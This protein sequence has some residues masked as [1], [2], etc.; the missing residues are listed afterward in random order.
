MGWFDEQIKQRMTKDQQVFEESYENFASIFEKH[1]R[2]EFKEPVGQGKNAIEQILRYFHIQEVEDTSRFQTI[3]ELLEHQLRPYGI[4]KR[5][6][7]LDK[8]W[9]RSCAGV[10][11]AKTKNDDIVA[12]IPQGI[13]G[14]K[15][16]DHHLNKFVSINKRNADTILPEA[17][18][19]YKSFPLRKIN[20]KDIIKYIFQIPTK[21]EYI[22]ML[23][24]TII[25]TLVGM[26]I[27]PIYHLF[28]SNI[29]ESNQMMLLLML[30]MVY[31]CVKLSHV[32]FT[33]IHSIY[34]LYIQTKIQL[35]IESAAMLRLLT[36]PSK[37]FKTY[38]I[39]EIYNRL[40]QMKSLSKIIAQAI[41]SIGFISVFSLIYISQIFKYA[42]TLVILALSVTLILFVY[43]V[44]NTWYFAHINEQR[45]ILE[46]KEQALSYGLINGIS[47]IKLA[48]AEKRVFSKWS[49]AYMK[50]ARK[51]YNLPWI[52]KYQQPITIFISGIGMMLLYYYALEVQLSVANYMAFI[53]A[54]GMVSGAFL[55]LSDMVSSFADIKPILQMVKPILETVP[56][57][58]TDKKVITR[59][60]GAI[61]VSHVNF[62]YAADTP[63]VLDDVT[64]KI[65]AGE[66][67]AIVGSTGSGK[68]T[69]LRLLLGFEKANRGT[70]YYDHQDIERIDLKSLRQHIGV[71]LQD[72]KLFQGDIFS[73][74]TIS[75]PNATL[76]EAWKACEEVGIANDIE[77]MP[78]G[79]NTLIAEGQQGISGGQKQRLLIARALC[80]KPKILM[81]DEATSAL[82]NISQKIVCDVLDKLKCTRII[83][84]HRLSTIKKCNRIIVFDKGRII[85]DGTYDEL[86][87][88]HAY[89]KE[90]VNRQMLSNE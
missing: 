70:V 7:K 54:Y 44:I 49:N 3:E 72:G 36:L 41:F 28:F 76:E 46:S 69:L 30:M 66:Y 60:S 31:L 12:L 58:Q 68:S 5:H 74:I 67:V 37:F 64:L 18:Y 80:Q 62:H 4:M 73:N 13:K 2:S 85:G 83:V 1:A 56:E 82:D 81:F 32:L 86:L 29:I 9:Y 34:I 79:M 19:F 77:Q 20:M 50:A 75:S 48:G 47:K 11:L 23:F 52:I 22:M 25:L 24:I 84:A 14:Y 55:S 88:S 89:F 65:R 35:A 33:T 53:S 17:L 42:P 78:M 26:I 45:M 61:E 87:E 6:V 15:F 90:L 39:G 10:M 57:V 38:S 59:L 63:L 43:T 40:S 16:Y 8:Q 71:V 51:K 27:P 21:A